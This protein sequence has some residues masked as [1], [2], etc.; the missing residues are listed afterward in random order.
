MIV[1]P[2][3][4]PGHA[5]TLTNTEPWR[6]GTMLRCDC[7]L[8]FPIV[9]HPAERGAGGHFDSPAWEVHVAEE[10]RKA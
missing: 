4:Q 10:R 1:N 8:S 3:V 6:K 2:P 5:G 7:G 9:A